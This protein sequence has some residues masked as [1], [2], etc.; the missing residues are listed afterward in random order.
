MS[1]TIGQ[2]LEPPAPRTIPRHGGG[3]EQGAAV[4]TD[5]GPGLASREG[6]PQSLSLA[7]RPCFPVI[8][9]RGIGLVPQGPWVTDFSGLAGAGTV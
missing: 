9:K 7:S 4:S 6:T 1:A 8:L 5:G 3:K 2:F